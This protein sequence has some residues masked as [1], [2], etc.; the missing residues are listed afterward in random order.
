[1]CTSPVY[2]ECGDYDD[3]D[4]DDDE[5]DDDSYKRDENRDGFSFTPHLSKLKSYFRTL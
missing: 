1:M 5:A 2:H 4:D 3:D